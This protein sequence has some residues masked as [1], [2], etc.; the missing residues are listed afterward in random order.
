[1]RL[2]VHRSQFMKTQKKKKNLNKNNNK[3]WWHLLKSLDACLEVYFF[4]T[5]ENSSVSGKQH[6]NHNKDTET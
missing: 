2:D 6:M 4:P 5:P 1:M 3:A